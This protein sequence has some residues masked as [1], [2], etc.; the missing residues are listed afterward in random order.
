M[1]VRVNGKPVSGAPQPGQCLRT[2]LRDHGHFEV[3][4]GCD[5]GDCGACSVLID[6]VAVHSCV[7]PAFRA[8]GRDVK[9]VAGLGTSEDLHP[10]QRRFVE[11]AGFQCGFCTAG[12]IT[13]A[14][15]FTEEQRANLAEHLKGNLCRCTGYR[16]ITDALDGVSN[17]EKSGGTTASVGAPAA[18]RVATGTEQ[19]TMDHTPEGLLH[20]AVL[21]SPVA[22]ARIVAIDTSAAEAVP[23]VHLVL[24]Y[25]DAP[26]V[27]FSTARH[28]I[29]ED[30]PDDTYVLDSTVRFVGQRVAAVVADSVAA[31]EKACRAIAVEYEQLPAVFDPDEAR[32]PGAPLLHADKGPDARIADP[33]RN[34]VAELHGGIGDVEQAVAAAHTVVRGRY[35]TQR[36]QHVHLE[37]HGCTGWVDEDGRLTI[38]TSTQVPFLVRDEL[39]RIFRLDRDVVRVFATRV[40]GGFGA[41]QEMLVEDLV[42]LAV[43]RLSRPV[44][45]EFSRSDEFTMAPCRHPFR[46]DV[47]VA[48]DEDGTLTALAVDVLTD[49]G[50]YGNHSPGVMFHGCAESVAVYRCANK[51][52]DAQSVYTNNLPSG[53]FRGYG[54]GQV[55]FAI[56]SA[57]DELAQRLSI[58]PFELRRRNVVRPGDR[59]IDAHEPEDL[60]FGSYGLDQCLDLTQNALAAG[61]G[62]V[63]P[64]GWQVGEGMA[65]AMIATLPPRGHFA[66]AT[67]TLLDDGRYELSVGTAEFGNGTTTVHSQ[68]VATL[69]NTTV[70]RVSIRQSDT[71]ASGY[72]TGAFGSAGIVVAGR[73]VHQAC[74]ALRAAIERAAAELTGVDAVSCVVGPHGVQCRDRFVPFTELALPLSATGHH[75]GTPRSVAF[76][77]Q[78]FRVAVNPETGEVRILQSVQAADAGVVL[79]P[80]QCRGQ[81]EGGVAQAIGSALYEEMR[82]GADGRVLTQTLRNYHIP[83]LADIP[84]TK[85]YFADTYDELGPLGAKSMS[86]SPYNPVAPALA[87]AIARAVGVRPRELPMTPARIWRAL[88]QGRA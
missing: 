52:I 2:F 6:D 54:L 55:I 47:T 88:Q 10:M 21:G 7:Y 84:Q 81:V 43:L 64:Q 51:R 19:Y 87:N 50:A 12:M 70:D 37:T 48:A 65:V 28:E 74:V 62:A 71:D 68:L 80:E 25:L 61:N 69:M 14:S 46:V 83:Q 3:K 15:T 77:V 45:Y 40:G 67:V 75:D 22:H 13:T 24:T 31:A 11:A 8:D 36:V 72:D 49:A 33:S 44:R 78:G 1:S 73:A 32:S 30:D 66:D 26:R 27:A 18:V 39:C 57:L 42:A 23:G 34:V 4:K 41:K 20:L 82:V 58:D 53:A 56:E 16:S 5:A 85:V 59:L 38:R 60:L 86:E 35:R 17:V 29:R 63:A 76:N 9:T 79:N